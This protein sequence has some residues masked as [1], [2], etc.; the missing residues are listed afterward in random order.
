MRQVSSKFWV[1]LD[2]TNLENRY[3]T[4]ELAISHTSCTDNE[5]FVMMD[6]VGEWG[7][8]VWLLGRPDVQIQEYHPEFI[9][10]EGVTMQGRK[11]KRKYTSDVMFKLPDYNVYFVY[12]TK[13]ARGSGLKMRPFMIDTAPKTKVDVLALKYRQFEFDF[14]PVAHFAPPKRDPYGRKRFKALLPKFGIAELLQSRLIEWH[15][16]FK[17]LTVR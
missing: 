14:I 15:L 11:I 5:R 3:Q 16:P 17:P 2:D 1:C 8:L 4:R 9:V 10:A 7:F 12:D 13:G 6:S